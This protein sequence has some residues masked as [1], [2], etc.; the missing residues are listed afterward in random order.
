M[1]SDQEE[2]VHHPPDTQ[3]SKCQQLAHPGP[4][5]AKAEP[6]QAQEPEEDGVQERGHEVVVG[7]SD[8]GKAAPQEDPRA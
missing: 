6:V 2:D 8:A 1:T 7:V 5:E 4:S 3:T